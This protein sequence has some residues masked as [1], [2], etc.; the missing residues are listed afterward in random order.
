MATGVALDPTLAIA[1]SMRDVIRAQNKP[2]LEEYGHPAVLQRFRPNKDVHGGFLHEWTTE[3]EGIFFRAY[4]RWQRFLEDYK[5]RGGWVTLGTDAGAFYSL[6]G[7]AYIREMELLQHA[8]FNPLEVV[9][10]ATHYG[11]ETILRPK[12]EAA[13]FGI[14][15]PRYLADLVVVNGNPLDD[16]KI[17]YGTGV[18][19]ED[20]R[21]GELTESSS[22][23]FTIKDGIV[24]DVQELLQ[25]VRSMVQDAGGGDR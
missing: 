9:R 17:L 2:W 16:F 11:A 22:I 25:D 13:E 10:S 8:G 24:Y 14:I 12:G 5:N 6:Y 15:A 20:P 23:A 4:A 1:E 7:F 18:E 21:T 19:R 3:H